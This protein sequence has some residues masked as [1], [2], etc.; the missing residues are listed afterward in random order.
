MLMLAWRMMTRQRLRLVFM[1]LGRGR[2][3]GI[4]VSPCNVSL[5]CRSPNRR[6]LGTAGTRM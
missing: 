2:F 4:G 3:L 1:T 6:I 5:E